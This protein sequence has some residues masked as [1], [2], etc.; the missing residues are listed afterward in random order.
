M[1]Y[2]DIPV[3][4]SQIAGAVAEEE[5]TIAVRYFALQNGDGDL[6]SIIFSATPLTQVQFQGMV[7]QAAQKCDFIAENLGQEQVGDVPEAEVE[8]FVQGGLAGLICAM[9][10]GFGFTTIPCVTARFS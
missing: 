8:A 5:P 9:F 7:D 3:T 6:D 2:F 1:N 4:D 10:P